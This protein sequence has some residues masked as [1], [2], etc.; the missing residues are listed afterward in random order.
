M[1]TDREPAPAP[2]LPPPP[3]AEPVKLV[4]HAGLFANQQAQ[5]AFAGAFGTIA[6]VALVISYFLAPGV[7]IAV[8]LVLAGALLAVNANR[9]W[10]TKVLIDDDGVVVKLPF[11]R[12]SYPWK[13]IA[14]VTTSGFGVV[15]ALRDGTKVTVRTHPDWA[16]RADDQD[17][18]ML[19]T[20]VRARLA[21]RIAR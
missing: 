8:G 6:T 15:L 5:F 20:A 11:S 19:A 7:R 14:D 3:P 16:P 10:P 13:S 12:E 18:K 1:T 21:S 9:F 17:T 4:L 2:A